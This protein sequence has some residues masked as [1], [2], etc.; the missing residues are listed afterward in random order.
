MHKSYARLSWTIVLYTMFV[1]LFG[2]FVRA[3]GSGAGCGDHWPLCNGTVLPR[4][5]RIETIIEFTHRI[6]SGLLLIL[7]VTAF[8][9]AFRK[10]PKNH[11]L[12]QASALSLFFV[13]VEAGIGAGLVLLQ[14]VEY[15]ATPLRAAAVGLHLF[16]TFILLGVMTY[17]AWYAACGYAERFRFRADART[18]LLVLSGLF[19]YGLVGAAGAVTALGD[20]LFPVAAMEGGFSAHFDSA[21]HFLVRLRVLHPVLAVAV[22]FFIYWLAGHIRSTRESAQ[23]AGPAPGLHRVTWLLQASVLVQLAL[24]VFNILLHAPVWM[25]LAH[26]ILAD[27]IL[28]LFVIIALE[29]L[30]QTVQAPAGNPAQE[31]APAMAGARSL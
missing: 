4:P 17:A 16:N 18:T 19:L 20:T 3:T 24:G 9:W 23:P 6:T 12:R 22:S 15:N 26:L 1:I 25:Q 27:V 30:G 8:V 21:S 11:A 13:V 29:T 7:V 14:L 31:K 28:I 10:F 2:A 5:E